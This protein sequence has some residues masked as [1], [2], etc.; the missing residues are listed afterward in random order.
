[1]MSGAPNFQIWRFASPEN[2]GLKEREHMITS[3]N[4]LEPL[5]VCAAARN[6]LAVR[7]NSKVEQDGHLS[8]SPLT[9]VLL[10]KVLTDPGL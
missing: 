3:R 9:K 8:H 6:S 2:T 4:Q 5:P 1:M 7:I 10:A